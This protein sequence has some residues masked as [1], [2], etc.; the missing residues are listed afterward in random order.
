MSYVIVKEYYGET[1]V[2]SQSCLVKDAWTNKPRL[3]DTRR[4]A[5]IWARLSYP[6]FATYRVELWKKESK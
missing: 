1:D 2:V 6:G 5:D 4:E 3:F